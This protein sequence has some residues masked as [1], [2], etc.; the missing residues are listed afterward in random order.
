MSN[1]NG[2]SDSD[3]QVKVGEAGELPPVPDLLGDRAGTQT[4][5]LPPVALLGLPEA[6]GSIPF[7]MAG[8]QDENAV[9][10]VGTASGGEGYVELD[11]GVTPLKDA[12][13]LVDAIRKEH[14][15]T[16]VP[17]HVALHFLDRAFE[18]GG[19]RP[20]HF[21][22]LV[23]MIDEPT[24]LSAEILDPFAGLDGE[25]ERN[26]LVQL[27]PLADE[28][29]GVF[30]GLPEIA[31]QNGLEETVQAVTS[32]VELN[33]DARRRRL[34]TVVQKTATQTLQGPL[35]NTWILALDVLTWMANL[36]GWAE[37]I[38]PARHTSLAL[39]A[40]MDGGDI[41]FFRLWTER[42]LALVA[43]M[44]VRKQNGDPLS[45]S[46]TEELNKQEPH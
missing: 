25:L 6:D 30:F 42:Q 37:V 10:F 34:K 45:A 7:L 39:Q 5:A 2:T 29:F 18:S 11:Q 27:G 38:R 36:K 8:F 9:V 15:L 28:R 31:I 4:A 3:E 17:P 22:V 43:E 40:G 13:V 35:R 46:L 44:V 24:R 1:K 41:P 16:D 26:A 14:G 21:N 33:D 20:E 12:H 19:K 23:D 32:Q